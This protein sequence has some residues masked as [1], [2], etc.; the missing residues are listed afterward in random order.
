M[1]LFVLFLLGLP[2]LVIPP[3][4]ARVEAPDFTTDEPPGVWAIDEGSCV[5]GVAPSGTGMAQLCH[6]EDWWLPTDVP[7]RSPYGVVTTYGTPTDD[8]MADYAYDSAYA[9]TANIGNNFGRRL[10]G[11]DINYR[12]SSVDL[13]D[14]SSDPTAGLGRTLYLH[15]EYDCVDAWVDECMVTNPSYNYARCRYEMFTELDSA[16]PFADDEF[17]TTLTYWSADGY[18]ACPDSAAWDDE[19]RS[20]GMMIW[21]TETGNGMSASIDAGYASFE[22]SVTDW[23]DDQGLTTDDLGALVASELA[24][25]DYTDTIDFT[26]EDSYTAIADAF[27]VLGDVLD[28][29]DP[30]GQVQAIRLNGESGAL[31]YYTEAGIICDENACSGSELATFQELA[32]WNVDAALEST[33]DPANFQI[34]IAMGGAEFVPWAEEAED[35]GSGLASHGPTSPFTYRFIQ[36]L[37]H[38]EYDE[39]RKAFR[40]VEASPFSHLHTDLEALDFSDNTYGQYRYFRMAAL[41]AMSLGFDRLLVSSYTIPSLGIVQDS[42]RC[43]DASSNEERCDR[44][45]HDAIVDVGAEDMLAWMKATL[46]RQDDE[47]VDAWCIPMELGS[48]GTTGLSF[49]DR[50]LALADDTLRYAGD[51]TVYSP[52]RTYLGHGCDLTDDEDERGEPGR[53]LDDDWLGGTVHPTDDANDLQHRIFTGDSTGASYAYEGRTTEGAASTVI[54]MELAPELLADS[55]SEVVVKLVLSPRG[56]IL[57]FESETTILIELSD[58]DS[59]W[60]ELLPVTLGIDP[61]LEDEIRTLTVTFDGPAAAPTAPKLRY[62]HVDGD[63][64]LNL[65]TARVIPQ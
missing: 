6:G 28:V 47:L 12:M 26:D 17:A 45:D 5:G 13:A 25:G 64:H 55:P 48:E 18:E 8:E 59:G 50:G 41:S 7:T 14:L 1:W 15:S 38:V 22:D 20:L 34:N 49:E 10:S 11:S 53:R 33:I 58:V 19:R 42:G 9:S 31:P 16:S 57:P 37:P 2:E 30:Y 32:E 40:V 52:L 65:L 36:H 3:L 61:I 46:G 44:Y 29:Y 43:W 23:L 21:G 4:D 51:A 60:R 54:A 63:V 35:I 56:D 27:T 24:D 62:S 39:D